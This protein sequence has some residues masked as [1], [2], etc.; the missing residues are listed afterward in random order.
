MIAGKI[1]SVLELLLDKYSNEQIAESSELSYIYVTLVDV[2]RDIKHNKE[3]VY[4]INNL[5]VNE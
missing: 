1:N 5:N 4:G 3:L 2:L